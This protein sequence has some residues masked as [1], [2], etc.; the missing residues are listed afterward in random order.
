MLPYAHRA[1]TDTPYASRPPTDASRHPFPATPTESE[2]PTLASAV[3]SHGQRPD[4]PAAI[5]SI[6]AE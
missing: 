5:Y 4:S 6:P 1:N 2:A 3:H